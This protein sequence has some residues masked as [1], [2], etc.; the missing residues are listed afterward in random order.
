LQ[1]AKKGILSAWGARQAT[2]A[3]DGRRSRRRGRLSIFLECVGSTDRGGAAAEELVELGQV[4]PGA[5]LLEELS[6]LGKLR[7]AVAPQGEGAAPGPSMRMC[8][9]VEVAECRPRLCRL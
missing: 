4:A 7:V 5:E 2:R 9:L 6:R 8:A 3:D 1:S